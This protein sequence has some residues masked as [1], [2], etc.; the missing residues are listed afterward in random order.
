V[1]FGS[2]EKFESQFSDFD[3]F[4]FF[5]AFNVL[6]VLE[7]RISVMEFQISLTLLYNKTKLQQKKKDKK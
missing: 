1:V 6:I 5:V 4:K 3:S 7:I 2:F